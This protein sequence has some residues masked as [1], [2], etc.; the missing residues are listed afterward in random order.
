VSLAVKLPSVFALE[1]QCVTLFP[2]LE[3]LELY[4][5]PKLRRLPTLSPSLRKLDIFYVGIHT[6]PRIYQSIE[7]NIS[8]KPSSLS[9]LMISSCEHLTSLEGCLLQQQE[10][11]RALTKLH[12]TNCSELVYPPSRGFIDLISLRELRIKQCPKV[13]ISTGSQ[14]NLLPSSLQNVSIE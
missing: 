4:R 2:R 7:S 8:T 3:T 1:N 14:Q 6:I 9:I 5:C 10:H 12:I 13:M 11:T